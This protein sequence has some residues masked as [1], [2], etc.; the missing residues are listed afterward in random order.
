MATVDLR[1][2]KKSFDRGRQI[3]RGISL[4]IADG[5]FFTLL[6][7]SGCGKSTLLRIVAGLE[8]PD[9]GLVFLNG[10]DVGRLAPAQRD[11]A[12][13]FQSYALYPHMSVQENVSMGLRLH[14][15]PAAEATSQVRETASMLGIA[16]LLDRRPAELS[17][18]EK[19][20][21]AL[22][23]AIVR[24]PKVFLLDE[25]L[26][27]LDASLRERTRAELRLLFRRVGGTVLYVTHDQ[28]EAVTLS[29][30][31]G[32]LEGGVLEQVAPPS[33]IHARPAT[34]FVAGFVGTPRINLVRTAVG[35]PPKVVP[36]TGAWSWGIRPEH[37]RLCGSDETGAVEGQV[38]LVE[39]L[40]SE[41]LVHMRTVFGDVR[42]LVRATPTEVAR[43]AHLFLGHEFVHWFDGQGNRLNA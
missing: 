31:V 13:V 9:E 35:V 42:A 3:L 24:R 11:V 15:V 23:R 6:G 12:M 5:E 22:A 21:V 16:G 37:V 41:S 40:G 36:P 2:I 25:P 20:R 8:A 38:V 18:G 1:G 39:S 32:V 14:G 4:S 28:V 19:Q 10:R 43:T 33:E 26:S 17:G 30:R 34:E 29:D 27:N 7:P